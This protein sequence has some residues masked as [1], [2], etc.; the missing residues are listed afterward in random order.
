MLHRTLLVAA[1]LETAY[2]PG[3]PGCRCDPA[4]DAPV[5]VSAVALVCSGRTWQAVLDGPCAPQP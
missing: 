5:C 1:V 2:Q 4:K 3:A